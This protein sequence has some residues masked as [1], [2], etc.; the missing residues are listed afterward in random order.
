MLKAGCGDPVRHVAAE[1]A[2][3]Q[4][5]SAVVDVR[6]FD[7]RIDGGKMDIASLGLTWWL[8]PF[9]G[10]NGNYRYIWNTLD[11]QEGSSSGLNGRILLLL[12]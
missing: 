9:F 10:V 5:R 11:G 8:T 4:R 7:G 6:S 1:R 12:E 2:T 3:H